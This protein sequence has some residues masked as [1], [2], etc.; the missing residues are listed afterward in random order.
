MRLQLQ[1]CLESSTGCEHAETLDKCIAAVQL[2]E[3]SSKHTGASDK[4]VAALIALVSSK[5]ANTTLDKPDSWL[6]CRAWFTCCCVVICWSCGCSCVVH[7]TCSRKFGTKLRHGTHITLVYL[8][9]FSYCNTHT[10]T[11]RSQDWQEG[12]TPAAPPH[13]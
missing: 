13:Q 11:D 9:H 10:S 3:Q 7:L 5:H 2:S 1:Y 12:P 8:L 4:P 6:L